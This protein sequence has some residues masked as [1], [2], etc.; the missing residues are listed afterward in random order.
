MLM[1]SSLLLPQFA[2]L[3]TL[4]TCEESDRGESNRLRFEIS[5]PQKHPQKH[6]PFSGELIVHP[7]ECQVARTLGI[8]R[9]W[10]D[11]KVRGYISQGPYSKGSSIWGLYCVRGLLLEP[12]I[13]TH[14]S[15]TRHLKSRND[16][17]PQAEHPSERVRPW[18][19]KYLTPKTPP[20]GQTH[21]IAIQLHVRKRAGVRNI[22]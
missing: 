9:P 18:N 6:F 21:V 22:V 19:W 1:G 12:T 16:T 11:V 14:R 5:P 7:C 10:V 15:G 8:R 2:S 13:Y 17:E 20:Y 4:G 3:K